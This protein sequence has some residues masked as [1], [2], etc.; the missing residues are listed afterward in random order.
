MRID[1]AVGGLSQ[2][3]EKMK[4]KQ[5]KFKNTLFFF[6]VKYNVLLNLKHHSNNF[7]M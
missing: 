5:T 7:L 1:D 2:L 6:R 4:A 3:E